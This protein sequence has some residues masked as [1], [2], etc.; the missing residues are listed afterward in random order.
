MMHRVWTVLL[1]IVI[2]AAAGC[3]APQPSAAKPEPTAGQQPAKTVLGAP[4]VL[5][6]R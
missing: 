1:A 2:A 3:H 5:R 6:R 4:G